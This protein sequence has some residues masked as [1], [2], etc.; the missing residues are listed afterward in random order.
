MRQVALIYNPASGQHPERRA[1]QIAK[2]LAALR[3]A[4]VEVKAIA[5]KSPESA[6][7]EALEAVRQG[8]DT[9][10]ACGGDGT[11]H[12]VMQSLVGGSTALGVIPMGTANALA[13]DLGVPA[14]PEKAVRMLLGAVPAQVFVP[15]QAPQSRPRPPGRACRRRGNSGR[16]CIPS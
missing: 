4:G 12:E 9:I 13:A 10:L 15:A 8:C 14:S 7:L 2:I 16:R 3:N 1:A 6:G 11:V 5:T